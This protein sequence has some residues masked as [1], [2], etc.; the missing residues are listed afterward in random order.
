M[1]TRIAKLPC[2]L[3]AL[4]LAIWF[5]GAATEGEL[6]NY[7]GYRTS[8]VRSTLKR[9][10][11]DGLVGHDRSGEL[12]QLSAETVATMSKPMERTQ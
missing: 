6:A 8:T 7:T 5:L 2:T 1:S 12:W 10:E 9:L 11:T 3:Q 4:M